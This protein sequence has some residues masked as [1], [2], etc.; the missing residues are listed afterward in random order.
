MKT[1]LANVSELY[2]AVQLDLREPSIWATGRSRRR[3]GL[4]SLV[5]TWTERARFR[6]ELGTKARDTPELIDDI[7]LTMDE[8]R[9]EL[10]KP[11]WRR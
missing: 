4:I 2:D 11:F 8:V 9:A 3:P 7:G 1:M 6:E 10:A 5:R